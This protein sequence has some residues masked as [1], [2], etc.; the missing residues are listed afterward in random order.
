MGM[1]QIVDL[2]SNYKEHIDTYLE[3]L[4]KDYQKVENLNLPPK[5]TKT[6]YDGF[7]MDIDFMG[8]KDVIF[9]I[10]ATGYVWIRWKDYLYLNYIIIEMT[11]AQY[12]DYI[13]QYIIKRDFNINNIFDS[14]EIVMETIEDYKTRMLNG[15]KFNLPYIDFI[16]EK[17]DGRHRV[18]AAYKAGYTKI[19][20]LILK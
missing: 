17:Q 4:N 6:S 2:I 20:C 14:N 11:P 5:T 19:P 7:S 16:R 13:Y 18:L 12:I 8:M 9:T 3:D 10:G 15:E 1:P